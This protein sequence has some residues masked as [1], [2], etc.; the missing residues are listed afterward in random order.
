[1]GKN[2]KKNYDRINYNENLQSGSQ[3][4]GVIKDDEKKK[5]NCEC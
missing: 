3:Y 4:L 5:K 1:L 2:I